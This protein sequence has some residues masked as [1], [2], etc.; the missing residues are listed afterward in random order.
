MAV[1]ILLKEEALK[2]PSDN[3]ISWGSSA[4]GTSSGLCQAGMGS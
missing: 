3:V 4:A 2:R 1:Q